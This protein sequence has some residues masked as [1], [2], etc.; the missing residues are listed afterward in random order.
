MLFNRVRCQTATTGTG[1]IE[2]G[3]TVTGFRPFH[4][5]VPDGARV[6]YVIEE[7]AEFEMGHGVYERGRLTR[8]PHTSSNGGLLNLTGNA[9]VAIAPGAGDL[10]TMDHVSRL[11]QEIARLNSIVAAIV[12][13]ASEVASSR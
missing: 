7:G 8:N 1:P 12:D 11:E 5:V 9:V 2:I 10:A 4:G 6:S 3:C 13:A